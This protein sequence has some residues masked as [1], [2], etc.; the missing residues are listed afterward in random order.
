MPFSHGKY[1]LVTK[2]MM[3]HYFLGNRNTM[4]KVMLTY[5]NINNLINTD[6]PH[7]FEGFLWKQINVNN[8]NI[9]RF[10]FFYGAIRKNNIYEGI[11]N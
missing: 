10:I 6:C 11:F 3:D 8:I 1:T 7:T 4:E 5:E 9:E 2:Y